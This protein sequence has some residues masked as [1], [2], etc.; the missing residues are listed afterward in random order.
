MVEKAI[1][2]MVK[3]YCNK[4]WEWIGEKWK[5]KREISNIKKAS[6]VNMK[7]NQSFLS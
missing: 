5:I 3:K 6:F 4:K 2:V 1:G 7:M